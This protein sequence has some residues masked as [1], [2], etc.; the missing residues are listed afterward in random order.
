M[1]LCV[2]LPGFLW[3][4]KTCL[5]ELCPLPY[6]CL[7]NVFGFQVFGPL[8]PNLFLPDQIPVFGRAVL[9]PKSFTVLEFRTS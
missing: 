7:E 3:L 4:V 8:E 1:V 2:A 6:F 9:D 5:P